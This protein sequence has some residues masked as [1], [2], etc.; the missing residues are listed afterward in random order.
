M[1]KRV[2]SSVPGVCHPPTDSS[3]AETQGL[4]DPALGSALL[5]EVLSVEASGCFPG[6]G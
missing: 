6:A 4:G 5:F 3:F 2:H 1:A